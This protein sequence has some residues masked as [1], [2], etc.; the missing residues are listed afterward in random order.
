M[1]QRLY[2]RFAPTSSIRQER[3]LTRYINLRDSKVEGADMEKWT[4]EWEDVFAAG[5][6]IK[7]PDMTNDRTIKDF[8]RALPDTSFGDYWINRIEDQGIGKLDFYQITQKYREHRTMKEAHTTRRMAAFTSATLQG[9]TA[10][11]RPCLCGQD[12]RFEDCYYLITTKRP[13][14]W[15]SDPKVQAK[16]DQALERSDKLRTKIKSLPGSV[17]AKGVRESS[18]DTPSSSFYTPAA[19]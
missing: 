4:E 15:K 7:L 9:R 5:Q 1:L 14:D 16:I 19:F 13:V 11:H 10:S 12:H 2:R 3:I 8:L 18:P 17:L 6:R